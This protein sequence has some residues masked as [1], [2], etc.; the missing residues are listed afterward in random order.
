M[1]PIAP[2]SGDAAVPIV[3]QVDGSSRRPRR[4][5]WKLR[6]IQRFRRSS[7][8]SLI[9]R[10]KR[11]ARLRHRNRSGSRTEQ[12]LPVKKG[13]RP[14]QKLRTR[15]P[16]VLDFVANTEETLAFFLAFK[17]K[18][19]YDPADEVLMDL[20]QLQTISPDAALVLIAEATRSAEF[21]CKLKGTKATA[22]AVHNL[23]EQI[24]YYTY[25]AQPPPPE[26]QK[27]QKI[28]LLHQTGDRTDPLVAKRI[29]EKFM[30]VAELTTPQVKALF[31][32]IVECM[33]N[34]LQHAYPE[35]EMQ[36]SFLR[37]RWW[38]LGSLDE[39]SH[40]ISFCFYDQGVGIPRTI[41]T[42][43]Q[44][45]IPVLSR[46][47]GEL[48]IQAVTE[49][50][51]RTREETRG[52]GLPTFKGFIDQYGRG[53]LAIVSHKTKCMFTTDAAPASE[54]MPIELGGTLISWTLR[55]R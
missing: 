10:R 2:S 38:L 9:Q 23:L 12:S 27:G 44:H 19:L 46:T 8:R 7:R 6:L 35:E 11:A 16:A 1:R 36:E 3:R 37:N 31:D 29:I 30:P 50:L 54:Q 40:E 55:T 33:A 39:S 26:P 53:H 22:P 47:D 49:G 20:S 28:F 17:A 51:S 45:R 25:Y 41:R 5:N 48:L 52:K 18:T 15:F 14:Y 42:R 32:A 13:F 43:W 4:L 34:V 21:G 24:G